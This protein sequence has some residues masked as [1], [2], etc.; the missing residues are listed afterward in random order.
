[1]LETLTKLLDVQSK[2]WNKFI[3][4][5]H[6]ISQNAA[7]TKQMNVPWKERVIKGQ[8]KVQEAEGVL[9]V[10]EGVP[11]LVNL[12]A[13]ALLDKKLWFPI[14]KSLVIGSS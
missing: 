1:M 4:K 3:G 6:L 11:C 7:L 12:N 10:V 9:E 14:E 13:D 8:K 2:H 5:N